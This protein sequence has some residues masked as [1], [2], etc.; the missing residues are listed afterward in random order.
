MQTNEELAAYYLWDTNHT[1]IKSPQDVYN[2]VKIDKEAQEHFI[3]LLLNT[4]NRVVDSVLVSLG[5]ANANV[6][7]PREVYRPAIVRSATSIAV[8]HNHPS[9]DPTPSREDIEITKKLDESGKLL[10]INLLDHVVC[11]G[12]G[13]YYS[14]KEC[15]YL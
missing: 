14:F 5:S 2:A 6:V 8:A 13:R 11:G 9:G 12:D 3:A 10:G 1:Y 4:K 7:H 15:G